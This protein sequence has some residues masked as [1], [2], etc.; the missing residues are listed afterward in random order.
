[1][2]HRYKIRMYESG[3]G[4]GSIAGGTIV[5]PVDRSFALHA[6]S[7]D[8]VERKIRKDVMN[9]KLS[10]G[11]VYQICPTVD[12]SERIRTVAFCPDG[13]AQSVILE[14]AKGLYSEFR[15]LRYA[16]EMPA[17]QNELLQPCPVS[18]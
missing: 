6:V 2:N 16:E 14:P 10:A 12:N 8:D 4:D 13:K 7:A 1:M 15:R 3:D 18:A 5:L 9:G 11:R 17:P